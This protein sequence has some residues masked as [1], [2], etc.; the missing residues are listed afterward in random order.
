MTQKEK[1]LLQFSEKKNVNVEFALIDS[2]KKYLGNIYDDIQRGKVVLSKAGNEAES[3]LKNA[4]LKAESNVDSLVKG[5]Q[6]AKEL[7]IDTKEI[8]DLKSRSQKAITSA[9]EVLKT[10]TVTAKV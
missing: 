5:E 2:A 6:M 7:G 3:I 8:T 10:A 1:I 4:I 9:K